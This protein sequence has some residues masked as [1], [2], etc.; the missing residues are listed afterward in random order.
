MSDTRQ[1]QHLCENCHRRCEERIYV[2]HVDE[3]WCQTC[4]DEEQPNVKNCMGK[5]GPMTSSPRFQPCTTPR[6]IED[7]FITVLVGWS[8]FIG[9]CLIIGGFL[10]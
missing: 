3:Y 6:Q 10:R 1:H 5:E 9:F 7:P 8:M 2:R 4:V